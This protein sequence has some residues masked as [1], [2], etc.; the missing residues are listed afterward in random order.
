MTMVKRT[1]KPPRNGNTMATNL[2]IEMTVRVRTLVV[3]AVTA[4][5]KNKQVLT[6]N[7]RKHV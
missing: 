1:V 2:S 6:M 7:H 4:T 3:I 5:K